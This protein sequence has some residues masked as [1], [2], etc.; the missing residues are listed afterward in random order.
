M[1][2]NNRPGPCQ[3]LPEK[4]KLKTRNI[5]TTFGVDQEVNRVSAGVSVCQVGE[6]RATKVT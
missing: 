5:Q 1:E 6:A 2:W 3:K 4:F